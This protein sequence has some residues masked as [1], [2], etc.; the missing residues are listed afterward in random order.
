MILWEG[1]SGSCSPRHR[2]GSDKPQ[3]QP[4]IS[5]LCPM[6]PR[7]GAKS[8]L[9]LSGRALQVPAPPQAQVWWQETPEQSS[10]F[11]IVPHVLR[12]VANVPGG[13]SGRILPVPASPG[14]GVVAKSPRA[15]PQIQHCAPGGAG[16]GHG[17]SRWSRRILQVGL[18]AWVNL[19]ALTLHEEQVS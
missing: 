19:V 12:D 11:S 7:D 16:A 4:P 9:G 5:A 1:R 8:P 13:S 14:T 18:G 6:F 15:L 2:C 3:S 17:L 10:S